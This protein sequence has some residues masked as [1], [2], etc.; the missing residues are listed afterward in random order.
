MAVKE[1]EIIWCLW[2]WAE[3]T[4]YLLCEWDIDILPTLY[5][6]DEIRFEYNQWADDWS[7]VSCTIFAAIWMLSDL[8]NYEF[9]T[10]QIKEVDELSYNNPKYSHIRTKW[11][12]WYVK[13]AVDLV[14]DWY[15]SSELSKKYGKV[16]YYRVSKYNT[17]L[18]EWVINKLYT[19]E[20]NQCITAEY[21]KDRQDWMIDWT[22]FW[23][24]T[25][26]HAIDVINYHGQRSVKNSYKGS[27]NNIYWLKNTLSAITN[28]WENFYVYT[29]VKEDNLEEIKRLNEIKTECNVTI[30]HLQ[31]LYSLVNDTNFQW[32]LHYMAEKLR[33]KIQDC[34]EILKKL[35]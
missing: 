16:A 24:N 31:K 8:I 10:A 22:N 23:P 2:D 1:E 17:D 29:L 25:N 20:W 33:K 13:Y 26:W 12:W 34:N 15:N 28:F 19:I 11:K 5:E 4:D 32:V 35:S 30:E 3:D 18:I 27:K 21:N 9:S 7:R 6:K 14:A